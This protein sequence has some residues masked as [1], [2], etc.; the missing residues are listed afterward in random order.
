MR[1][2]PPF[3][4]SAV[5][6]T[7]LAA[8]PASDSQNS[9]NWILNK[10]IS[11]EFN[12]PK[13]DQ[14]KWWIQGA[15][16]HYENRWKGRA[17]SQFAPEN[18]NVKDGHLIITSRWDESFQF[19][20]TT[21]KGA[22]YGEDK[23]GRPVPVTTGALISKAHFL[24]GYM[25]TRARAADGPVSSSFWTTGHGGELDVF[26]HYGKNPENKNAEKRY[27]TS[28]HDWRLPQT[29]PT[30]GKRIW[31]NEHYLPFRVADDFHIY[32]LEWDPDFLNIFIDGKLI[33]SITREEIGE[34][35][36]VTKEQKVWFDSELFPWELAP[37]KT[38]QAH[39]PK[40][41]S[42]FEVDYVR[43]WQNQSISAVPLKNLVTSPSFEGDLSS[44]VAKGSAK[45]EPQKLGQNSKGLGELLPQ[46]KGTI[47]Q[48][49]KQLKPNTE[50]ILS[51]WL[52]CPGTNLTNIYHNT[53]FGVKNYGGKFVS[54]RTFKPEWHRKSIQFTTG[55]TSKSAT[56]FYTNEWS[57]QAGQID[58]VEIVKISP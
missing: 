24:Y 47:E 10:E 54:I 22:S 36:V 27:H 37:E 8:N 56:I 3:I 13:I 6:S 45:I 5:A 30:Y 43:V 44:W 18:V 38:T 41:G 16:D 49:V 14:E 15:D 4:L 2:F 51:A 46:G 9:G 29:S 11:D 48:Q 42:R 17:P 7:T 40:D 34:A 1:L 26:E 58:S 52:R 23:N 19:S 25:E 31:T 20:E 39:F 21:D 28:F 32:G 57:N 55:P 12:A 33:R 50:Y 53:W 35:W